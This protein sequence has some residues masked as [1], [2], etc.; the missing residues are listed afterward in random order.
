MINALAAQ[1]EIA[2]VSDIPGT[3]TDPVF[4]AMEFL[5][6]GP[7]MIIDTAGI[8]DVGALG[9]LR[10]KKSRAWQALISIIFL[11]WPPLP[12]TMFY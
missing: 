11:R 7:C 1:Q 6:L 3:T 5:P 9:E 8:D 12:R 4:K 2:L 10:I